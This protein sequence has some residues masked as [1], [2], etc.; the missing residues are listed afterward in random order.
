MTIS[1]KVAYLKGVA[2]G[3]KLDPESSNEAK[4]ISIM[5]DILEDLGLTVQ[6]LEENAL[7]LGDEIDELS[8]DLA[9]VEEILFGEDEEDDAWD[10]EDFFEMDCPNCGEKL[11]IDETVLEEGAVE[12][13]S[14]GQKF[15]LETDGCCE[16]NGCSCCE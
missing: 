11:V 16:D 6:D 12:C 9:D 4:L 14:C 15:S 8:D 5:M 13:P 1:E 3:Q 7:A 2:E 10:D